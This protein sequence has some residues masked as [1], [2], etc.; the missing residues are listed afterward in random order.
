MPVGPFRRGGASKAD[1]AKSRQRDRRS[2]RGRQA[3]RE[4]PASAP[5]R[6]SSGDALPLSPE[7][8]TSPRGPPSLR[9]KRPAPARS[10][11]GPPRS[12]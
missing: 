12:R 7:V 9:G 2:S 11:E 1:K 5:P 6:A 4:L 10:D 8:A 3:S